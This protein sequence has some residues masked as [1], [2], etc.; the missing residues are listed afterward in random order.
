MDWLQRTRR[1]RTAKA[2]ARRLPAALTQAYG[3]GRFYT[4]GQVTTAFRKLRFDEH[5]LWIALAW[6]LDRPAFAETCPSEAARY[7][8]ARALTSGPSDLL[9]GAYAFE[10][11]PQSYAAAPDSFDGGHL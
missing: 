10:Q 8:E 1:R 3:A 2:I 6:F 11:P 4:P 5:H 7:D 9:R